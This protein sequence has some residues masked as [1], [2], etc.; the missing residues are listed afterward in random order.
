MQILLSIITGISMSAACGFRIF[1][2]FLVMSIASLSGWVSFGNE[3][4]WIGTYP[5][6]IVFGVA[7]IV[8]IGG[9]YNPWIDNMLDLISTPLALIAGIIL[10]SSI[11]TD[12]NPFWKW[13]LSI[14]AGG[15]A[16][17]NVQLLTVKAR[18][19]SSFITTGL[20]N[21]IVSTIETLSSIT[22]SFLS[23]FVPVVAFLLLLLIVVF[24]YKMIKKAKD[25]RK[26]NKIERKYI[27]T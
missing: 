17:I 9:Y 27:S 12:I 2:P 16:A 14:I 18:A 7:T 11:L 19:F 3:T 4:S 5:A 23:I 15:G 1:V 10:T 26:R 13:T 21:P 8:E 24:I 20:G 22:I 25:R 6:L